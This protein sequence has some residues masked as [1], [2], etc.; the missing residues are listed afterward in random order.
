[1]TVPFV[2]F[3]ARVRWSGSTGLGWDHYDRTHV[4]VGPPAEQEV[5]L[6]TGETKGDPRI[7]NA[8]PLVV[9]AASSCQ[10]LC[11]LHLS[12]K[13]RIGAEPRAERQTKAVLALPDDCL[14]QKT[15]QG[16]LEEI[17]QAR[18]VELG[19]RRKS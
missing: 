2:T 9:M 19:A 13:A 15:A 1:M 4:A 8:E 16:F 10:M 3:D 17:A 18:A 12:A 6:T 11:L 14:G 7:L 5:R